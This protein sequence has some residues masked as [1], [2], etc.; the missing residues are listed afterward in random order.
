[1][2]RCRRLAPSPKVAEWCCANDARAT[3]HNGLLE[4]LNDIRDK[5]LDGVFGP[6][7]VSSAVRKIGIQGPPSGKVGPISAEFGSESRFFLDV[8]KGTDAEVGVKKDNFG[9]RAV[10]M[11]QVPFPWLLTLPRPCIILPDHPQVPTQFACLVKHLRGV[12]G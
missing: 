2:E 1:M 9:L 8:T 3:I 7:T 6:G 11:W 10:G 4:T 5:P 12:L